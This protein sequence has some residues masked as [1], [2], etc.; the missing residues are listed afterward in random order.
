ML[1]YTGARRDTATA[2]TP[3]G[4]FGSLDA[5]FRWSPLPGTPD[6]QLLLVGHNLLN[7]SERNAVAFNKDDVVLPGRDIR[8]TVSKSF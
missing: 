5:Q 2:E 8:L 1:R 3:T 4:G 6:L 7:H